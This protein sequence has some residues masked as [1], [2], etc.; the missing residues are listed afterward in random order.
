MYIH[1]NVHDNNLKKSLSL[2]ERRRYNGGLGGRK[3]KGKCCDYII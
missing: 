3:N 2:K 1:I